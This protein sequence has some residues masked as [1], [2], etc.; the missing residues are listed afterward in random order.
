MCQALIFILCIVFYINKMFIRL[1]KA[2]KGLNFI[3]KLLQ[4]F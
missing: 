2:I 1:N 3:D 4:T